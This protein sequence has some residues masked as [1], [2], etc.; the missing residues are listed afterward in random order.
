MDTL[1]GEL[2]GESRHLGIVLC[3]IVSSER[4]IITM[5]SGGF[6]G[7]AECMQKMMHTNWHD[8]PNATNANHTIDSARYIKNK[9]KQSFTATVLS[10]LVAFTSENMLPDPTSLLNE[11]DSIDEMVLLIAPGE[12][13]QPDLL[14]RI[15]ALRTRVACLRRHIYTKEKV[16]QD[17]ISPAMQSCFVSGYDSSTLALYKEAL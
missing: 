12:R 13:D 17:C 5:H 8:K 15:A 11:V 1:R 3:S 2:G 4:L 7:L 10:T 6:A 16:V 14:R 9:I